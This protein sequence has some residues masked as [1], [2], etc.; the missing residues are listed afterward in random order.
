[1][2]LLDLN[3]RE[4]EMVISALFS[5]IDDLRAD[6]I[7]LENKVEKLKEQLNCSKIPNSSESGADD[8]G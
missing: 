5:K 2:I 3:E 6:K 1:M 8:N 7:I 4:A